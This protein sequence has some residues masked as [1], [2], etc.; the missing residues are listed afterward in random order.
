[1]GSGGVRGGGG[2]AGGAGPGPP[3]GPNSWTCTGTVAVSSW[4]CAARLSEEFSPTA[5]ITAVAPNATAARVARARA[6]LAN[7][8]ASPRPTGRGRRSLAASRWAA[9]PRPA[10]GARPAA[11]AWAAG[12]RPARS[13]GPSAAS[14]V[15]ASI[16]AGAA[17]QAHHGTGWPPAPQASADWRSTWTASRLP[18]S[19]P[20]RQPARAGQPTRPRYAATTWAGVRPMDFST[21]IRWY[22]ATTAPLTT[23]PTMS[24]AITRP[25]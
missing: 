19:T 7:G 21:P 14:A 12:S 15:S 3:P 2:A 5:K 22:P 1:G 18:V 16:P 8:A 11:I 23:L 24:T 13:A 10:R 9:Y 6:G 4:L 20:A 25:M 17:T